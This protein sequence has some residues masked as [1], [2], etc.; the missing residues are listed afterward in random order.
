VLAL[1]SNG[2]EALVSVSSPS[3]PNRVYHISNLL[4]YILAGT[5]DG[6]SSSMVATKVADN[7]KRFLPVAHKQSTGIYIYTLCTRLIYYIV[8]YTILCI[9][10]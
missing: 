1:A 2:Q 5:S 6:N 9:S 7:D 8:I 4:S 10:M 3:Q